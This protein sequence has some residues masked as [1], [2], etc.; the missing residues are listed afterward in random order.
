MIEWIQSM[1]AV[2]ELSQEGNQ[3]IRAVFEIRRTTPSVKPGYY[4]A[5]TVPL[6]SKRSNM[7]YSVYKIFIS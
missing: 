2:F 7:Q 4:Y 3:I 5:R 1:S 6:K